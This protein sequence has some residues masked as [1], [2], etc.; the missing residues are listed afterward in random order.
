VLSAVLGTGLSTGRGV[1][2]RVLR[3][4]QRAISRG[5]QGV[6]CESRPQ[7]LCVPA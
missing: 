7:V 1:D 6:S 3:S 5:L 2:G 4:A